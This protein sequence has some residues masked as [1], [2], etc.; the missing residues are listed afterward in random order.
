[1][2]PRNGSIFILGRLYDN[3]RFTVSR[4]AQPQIPGVCNGR[5]GVFISPCGV[6]APGWYDEKCY[7]CSGMKSILEMVAY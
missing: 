5:A 4:K 6:S 1:M 3:A 7:P 2:I